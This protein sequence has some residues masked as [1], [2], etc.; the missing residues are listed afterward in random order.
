MCAHDVILK[1]DL[2]SPLEH[3]NHHACEFW[4]AST[5]RYYLLECSITP[6]VWHCI[7]F[8]R[9][10]STYQYDSQEHKINELLL[11]YISILYTLKIL[12]WINF[13]V[14]SELV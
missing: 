14:F 5:I 4:L 8:V 9:S 2:M 6:W 12:R 11:Q 7:N 1:L 10:Q 13:G 3:I